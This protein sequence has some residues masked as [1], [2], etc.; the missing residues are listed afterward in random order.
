MS[1]KTGETI[2]DVV[3]IHIL[4]PESPP[5]RPVCSCG[6]EPLDGHPQ[7]VARMIQH[8][9]AEDG[10]GHQSDIKLQILAGGFTYEEL[11]RLA[12]Q[13]VDAF[14]IIR[15]ITRDEIAKRE[16]AAS[17]GTAPSATGAWPSDWSNEI[18]PITGPNSMATA[19]AASA[20]NASQPP[21][22]CDHPTVMLV[23]GS[24][25]GCGYEVD[26]RRLGR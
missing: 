19:I 7:H 5:N 16:R 11:Q 9:I 20:A 15:T 23:G 4:D 12:V 10:V 26:R 3:T 8:A 14:N 25:M 21:D 6:A 13:G 2:A 22:W 17:N 18:W 1:Q 24:C